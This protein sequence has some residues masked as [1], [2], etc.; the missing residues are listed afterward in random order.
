MNVGQLILSRRA[1]RAIAASVLAL[2]VA[3]PLSLSPVG[4]AAAGPAVAVPAPE[5]CDVRTPVLVVGGTPAGVAAAVAAARTGTPV[6]MTEARPYLGGD[7]TGAMLNMFDMDFGLAGEQLARGV[8]S[9]VYKQLGMTFDD[10]A[11]KRV[12]MDEVR[13]EPLIT[14]K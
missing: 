4:S 1:P 11:A 10:K 6:I 14:L 2:S 7:L 5:A 8:F 13:R 12:I 9:E 3:L